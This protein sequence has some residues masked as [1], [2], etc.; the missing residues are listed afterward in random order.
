[1]L[2]VPSAASYDTIR[3]YGALYD[4]V[5]AYAARR[6]IPFYVEEAARSGGRVL[7]I[8]CGTGR[9]LV[10]IARS[11]CHITGLDGSTEMLARCHARLAAEPE[12]VRARV[13]LEHGDATAFDL[14]T[15]YPLILAPFRILQMLTSIDE[16]LGCV[17]SVARHLEPGGRFMFDVYN[18]HFQL[19]LADRSA[20]QEDTPETTLPDGRTFRRTSR[21]NR[22]RMTEQVNDVELFY[23]V[24]G[25]RYVHAF[26]MRWFLRAELEHLLARA[27]MRVTNVYGDFDR[28]AYADASPELIVEATADPSLR[29]G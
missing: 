20:E 22:V 1:M 16:Q 21:I 5:P 12:E 9:V 10:P 4:A 3:D 14:G 17:R 2:R 18:P 24:D 27:G 8:G 6:D 26:A 23:Y 19:L 29:P 7:E 11:G 28:S 13:A 15:T 25:K